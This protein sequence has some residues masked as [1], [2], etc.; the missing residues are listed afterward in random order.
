MYV[1]SILKNHKSGIT[2][3]NL[4]RSPCYV[5]RVIMHQTLYIIPTYTFILQ[6][7]ST[8]NLGPSRKKSAS[9][10]WKD[11]Q[12]LYTAWLAHNTEVWYLLPDG[13]CLTCTL[14]S[15]RY[16]S[17]Y[18]VYDFFALHAIFRTTW[19]VYTY[20]CACAHGWESWYYNTQRHCMQYNYTDIRA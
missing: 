11:T 7:A 13:L 4:V 2:C 17:I 18:K 3:E 19:I 10:P 9:K 12:M 5:S 1:F 14:S 6:Q 15:R 16:V 8:N 20:A